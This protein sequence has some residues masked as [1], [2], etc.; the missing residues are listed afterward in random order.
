MAAPANA[1]PISYNGQEFP[2]RYAL[3]EH[4]APILGKPVITIAS[5]I[6][7]YNGDVARVMAP[8]TKIIYSFEGR[9]FTTR[10]ALAEHLA[11]LLGK[12]ARSVEQMLIRCRDDIATVLARDKRYAFD[13]RYFRSRQAVARHLS[14]EFDKSFRAITTMLQRCDDDIPRVVARLKRRA[15]PVRSAHEKRR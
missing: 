4:L 11:P 14:Q 1:R 7:R 6:S 3:A 5:A 9:S 15:P 8:P 10:L 12:P 2:S 13:G